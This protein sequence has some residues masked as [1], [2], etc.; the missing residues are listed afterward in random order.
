MK[1]RRRERLHKYI[2]GCGYCS[3]RRAERLIASGL[4]EV[5]GELIEQP[6]CRVVPGRD[7]VVINGE[8]IEPPPPLT[9]A[10]NKP[11]GTITSTHDTHDRL[12]VMDLLPKKIVEEG[13]LP[14]GRLDLDTEGLLILTNDGDLQHRITH[15]RY[16]CEKEYRVHLGRPPSTRERERLEQGVFIRE[17]GKRTAAA[18]IYRIRRRRD[19]STTLHIK[20][21]EGMKRQVRRMFEGLGIEVLHLKRIA[22]GGVELGGLAT[23][24]WRALTSEEL[25]SLRGN[26][27]RRKRH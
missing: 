18:R 23:G 2:A 1:R 19:G 16:E 8:R 13:V 10:L 5:N 26:G 27:R 3:R 25:A 11:P 9:I 21:H 17:L 24:K 6:G 20:I 4:V 15:P 22:I 12:T 14:A 7:A